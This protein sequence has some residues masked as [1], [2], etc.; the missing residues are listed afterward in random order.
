M[1]RSKRKKENKAKLAASREKVK[2]S[3][4]VKRGYR[5]LVVDGAVYSW[6][7]YG[8]RVEIRTPGTLGLK[9]LV[10]IWQLQEYPSKE[11]WEAQHTEDHW[12]MC[13]CFWIQPRMVRAYI[14][15]MRKAKCEQSGS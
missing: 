5:K 15:E 12:D 2:R 14:D 7:Y 6:R 10:P 11:E 9:W 13:G 8:E 1:L 4:G 3:D